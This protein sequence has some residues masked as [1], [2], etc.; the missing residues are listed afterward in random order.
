MLC[1]W[2]RVPTL[3]GV[4]LAPDILGRDISIKSTEKHLGFDPNLLFSC[5]VCRT[6]YKNN[7]T[8]YCMSGVS[9]VRDLY[10]WVRLR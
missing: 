5:S 4:Q 6:K 3:C 9:C 7:N 10:L 2:E 8:H 1:L